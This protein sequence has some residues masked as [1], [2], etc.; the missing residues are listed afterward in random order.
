[1]KI[2]NF[3]VENFRGI[4]RAEIDNAGSAVVIAGPNGSGKSCVL[5]AIRL[6]KSAYG[7]YQQ[8]ELDLWSNEFQLNWRGGTGDFRGM[9]RDKNRG[10]IIEGE[11][12][13]SNREKEFLLG[14][15]QWM[16]RELAWK[17]KFPHLN[18]HQGQLRAIA[19]PEMLESIEEVNNIA[20][21]WLADL[22]AELKWRKARGHI[23]VEPSGDASRG[24][25]IALQIMFG[26]FVPEKMGIIDY[27]G[28]YRKYDREQL[29]TI[30]LK[31]SDEE[32]KVKSGA[33]Y[34]YETKYANL[35]SAM[36]GEY[37]RELLERDAV[38][39]RTGKT[40]PLA[41]TLEELFRMFLPG[42]TFKGPV[43]VEGGELAFPVW[44]DENTQHD[45]NELS[46]G[47][48]E[49]LFAYLRARTLSPRQSVLLIDE[50]EL[51]LNPGLVQG[52]PQ[53]YEKHIGR[54]LENQIWLVT[55][56]DRFLREALD[57]TGMMVYHMQH[58]KAASGINQM[59]RIE[60]KTSVERLFI[61][62]VGDLAAYRP[63]G[64]VVLLEGE[65]SK[66][67][68]KMVTRLFP[69][70]AKSINFISGGAKTNVK[71][72]QETIEAMA[73]H[74]QAQAEVFSIVDPDNDIWNRKPQ[75]K[76]TRLEW[77]V[78][79][80]ENYLL[81]AAFI[82]E[83]IGVV[84]IE[85]A[86]RI[87]EIQIDRLLEDAA[88]DL[89]EELAVQK[90]RDKIWRDLRKA[91]EIEID[92]NQNAS[93]Q[94]A[95]GITTAAQQVRSLEATFGNEDTTER[96]LNQAKTEIREMW[97]EGLWKTNFPGRKILKRFCSKLDR[98]IEYL[99]L[100]N[101]IV[102]EMAKEEF[103]PEGMAK[104]IR[105]IEES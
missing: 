76:G 47:E 82:K 65:D 49:I 90:V 12:E 21:S 83:A 105:K 104:I 52:L 78:Y 92:K 3:Q 63:D 68:Q 54:D 70:A 99:S 64:K 43:A 35:K 2:T 7:S 42:K 57:T 93:E 81:E 8:S 23:K 51:H 101:A 19:T 94:L 103:K 71:R 24:P 96:L 14:E 41:K 17:A 53:F 26:F 38:G 87:S 16:I 74:G 79:H 84:N 13:I 39:R 98:D 48:K 1:M 85:G 86:D 59:S 102:G 25:G 73:V 88:E 67:D 11:I 40:K 32:E 55:H 100:R 60:S 58:A 66:F 5:D 44:V 9:L 20:Q 15:G 4:E 89:I 77:T 22:A 30:A 50:P 72:L 29:S 56:S 34:N 27:H 37:V 18:T 28:S 61:D 75:E 6:F 46:S 31:E 33:L 10:M 95:T 62:L 80:V 91:T 97:S 69:E 36:A 45:I